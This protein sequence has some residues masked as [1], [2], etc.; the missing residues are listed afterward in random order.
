MLKRLIRLLE[1]TPESELARE[2][3]IRRR[4]RNFIR[5]RWAARKRERVRAINNAYRK[6]NLAKAVARMRR[7]YERNREKWNAYMRSRRERVTEARK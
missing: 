3:E 6:R 7:W 2:V 4:R 5:R 1:P